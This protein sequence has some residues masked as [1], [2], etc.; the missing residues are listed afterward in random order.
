MFKKL[1]LSL[2]TIFLISG[3]AFKN[4]FAVE[5]KNEK[6]QVSNIIIKANVPEGF[7]KNIMINFELKDGTNA[8]YTLNKEQNYI[9]KGLIPVGQAKLSFASVTPD[10]G[11]YN[12]TLPKEI[13]V[14]EN[15]SINLDVNVSK[16][17][18]YKEPEREFTYDNND[19]TKPI[20][21]YGDKYKGKSEVSNKPKEDKSVNK[22][23]NKENEQKNNQEQKDIENSNEQQN[24]ENSKEQA[25]EQEQELNKEN[26]EEDNWVLKA[27]KDNLATIIIT[28][29]MIIVIIVL[30]IKLS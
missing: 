18:G 12:V 4:V 13:N 25:K 11:A 2:M 3:F 9:Y 27:I 16:V 29:I 17:E 26:K 23:V 5:V 6:V 1:I 19:Y 28:I 7:D 20:E 15:K 24:Q 10:N 21:D 8:L 22:D 14:E 30:K